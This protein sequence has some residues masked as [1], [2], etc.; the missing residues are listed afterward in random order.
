MKTMKKKMGW[1]VSWR[2]MPRATRSLGAS[3]LMLSALWASACSSGGEVDETQ[4]TSA[5]VSTAAL[6]V[7]VLTNSCVANQRQDI[8]EVINTGPTPVKLSDLKIKMWADDTSGQ[9]LVPHVWTGGCV[10]GANNNPSCVHQATGVTSVPT[11][12][13]PAC[14]PDATHQANWEITISD[15]DSTTIPAGGIWNNIQTA[16][17]L[18]NYSNFTPGTADWFSPCLTGASYTADTHF[19]LYYQG[20][21][22]FSNGIDTPACRGPQG[23][24][25]VPNYTPPPASPLVGPVPAATPLSVT[26]SLPLRNAA[27]LQAFIDQSA[28]PNSATYRHHLSPADIKATYAP[29]DADYA[30]VV[31]WAQKQGFTVLTSAN[32]L[33]LDMAGTAAQVEQTFHA[34]LIFALRPDG[35]QFFRLDRPPSVDLSVPLLGV[36]G[37][38]NYVIHKPLAGSG[39]KAGSFISSDLRSAYLNVSSPPCATLDGTGQSVGLFQ[40][41]GFNPDDIT[42]YE[43]KTG[44]VGVP[45]V[46]VLTAVDNNGTT[47][48]TQLPVTGNLETE[49]VSLDIE[50][51]I[52]M[53]PKAQ[54]VV[55]EG[56]NQE[57]ILRVMTNNPGVSQISSSWD[58]GNTA[59]IST[60]LNIMAAQGQTFF[61]ASGDDGAYQPASVACPAGGGADAQPTDARELPYATVVGGTVLQT[62]LFEQWIGESAWPHGGGGILPGATIP[63][64]QVGVNPAD[65]EVSTTSRNVPDVSMI[66]QGVYVVSSDC[67][68]KPPGFVTGAKDKAGNLIVACPSGHLTAAQEF[69]PSGTSIAAPLW[70]GFMALVNQKGSSL[71]LGP[72][73]YI[74]PSIY[75]IG[76]SAARYA[77]AF[78]DINAGTDPNGCG[79]SYTAEAGYDLATGLGT[80]QCGLVSELNGGT[81]SITVG[82]SATFQGGP[83]VCISGQKFTPNGQVSVSYGGLPEVPN[84]IR[85]LTTSLPVG[86]DGSIKLSDNEVSAVSAALAAGVSACTPAEIASGVVSVNVVDN[87]TGISATTTLPASFFCQVGGSATFG[88]GCTTPTVAIRYHQYAACTFVPTAPGGASTGDNAA[89]VVFQIDGFDNE[90]GSSVP[91]AFD[92][93]KLFVLDPHDHLQDFVDPNLQ[94][95]PFIFSPFAAVSTTVP[96]LTTEPIDPPGDAALVVTT[97]TSDG[98]IEANQ[99]IYPLNYNQQT[100]DAVVTFVNTRP[101]QTSTPVGT[102][103]CSQIGLTAP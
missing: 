87:T 14:G 80:P 43:T 99:T 27:A 70:A 57:S 36:S 29:L 98:A 34:N 35:T 52:A 5:I 4:R 97:A 49:E 33:G 48:P 79:F 21:L 53:A 93:A 58:I 62:N 71:G 15:T 101:S 13:S 17:N 7:K 89:Y 77:N 44:L 65:A 41:T 32:N 20:T 10:S 54:V 37:L 64:Y 11:P 81:P 8:F 92:P 103:D 31:A 38:D 100:G 9:A 23:T 96:A 69:T 25:V 26:V 46:K 2:S 47:T 16:L 67:D 60:L 83:V 75:Q 40:M 59:P 88:G 86:L 56:Q 66:A 19:A 91:F 12:F 84:G 55:F 6:Q 68:A 94:I 61:L 22:V 18:A 30:T 24:Q 73:G 74:N 85:N 102:D 78:H 39:P 1:V 28:D 51:A 3:G 45:A 72:I 50:M 63:S 95:Y 42:T 76:A 82:A 90:L